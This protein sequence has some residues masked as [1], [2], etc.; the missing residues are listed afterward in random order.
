MQ[1]GQVP[2]T[3]TPV[4]PQ[5]MYN[6]LESAWPGIVGGTPTRESLLTLLAQW[7][8]ETASGASMIQY[9]VGN[10][11]ATD[12]Y[13]QGG[14]MYT[15]FMTTE[16]SGATL[17]HLSQNF[18]AYPDLVSGVSDYLSAM[19]GRFGSAWPYVVSGDVDGFA[20]ALKDEGYYTADESTY[21][22]GLESRYSQ[23]D[24]QTA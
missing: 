14:G 4:S 17:Q 19:I 22:A 12:S 11:K 15:S 2:A 16:G 24:S 6:A 18:K 20:Q 13:I 5:D 3:A 10:F 1:G 23:M 8:L 7:S 9:N 21:A